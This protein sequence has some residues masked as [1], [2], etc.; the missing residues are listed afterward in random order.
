[1]IDTI[2]DRRRRRE[3][4]NHEAPDQQLGDPLLSAV[5]RRRFLGDISEMTAWRW[6][7]DFGLPGPDL[8]VGK[9][10]YWR[11]STVNRWVTETIA[12]R[13]AAQQQST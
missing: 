10:R 5:G 8:V 2:L 1:M 4:E 13:A 6:E 7:R 3:E 11:L 9:R 12:A